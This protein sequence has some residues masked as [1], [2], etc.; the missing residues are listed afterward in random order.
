LRIVAREFATSS[1]ASFPQ[2][3]A[4]IFHALAATRIFGSPTFPAYP[5]DDA[6]VVAT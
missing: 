1:R 3:R 5:G 6:R 4:R 2:R